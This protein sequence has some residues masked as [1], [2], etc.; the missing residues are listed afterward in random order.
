MLLGATTENPSFQLNS[1][2]LSRCKVI[3]LE[4][5]Q[6]VDIRSILA[7]ASG[8]LG[9]AILKEDCVPCPHSE[10][11]IYIREDAL[12]ALAELCDG[13][14]RI[15]LNGLQ[16]TFQTKG[17]SQPH[18]N[19]KKEGEKDSLQTLTV[20]QKEGEVIKEKTVDSK[21]RKST[22][23]DSSRVEGGASNRNIPMDTTGAVIID[24][25]D[26]KSCL[27]KTHLLYDRA[28]DEHYHSIS[29]LHKSMR[30][31][32]ANA[33]LYWLARMLCG[34]EDPLYVARRVIRFASEDIGI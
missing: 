23:Q 31:S 27:Q 30:G 3:V 15:A 2:L 19:R 6:S 5:L 12:T 10:G 17:A 33:S 4:K 22:P 32:D 13:D 9:V 7:R 34:G 16:L 20:P 11:Q 26:V 25:K 14:A 24:V 29:A 28:G 8:R 21:Q 18:I 1:A